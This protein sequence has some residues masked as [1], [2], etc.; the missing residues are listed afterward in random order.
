MS[1]K[2]VNRIYQGRVVKV[3]IKN[4]KKE[5]DWEEYKD[6]E[7]LLLNH[8]E[9]FQSAVNYYLLCFVALAGN[10]N[11][12][13]DNK[14]CPVYRLRE[15]MKEKWEPFFYKGL[16]R[17]G[18]QKSVGKHLFLDN[19]SPKFEECLKKVIERKENHNI[20]KESLHKALT[21]LLKSCS[22]SNSIQ[23]KGREFAPAFFWKSYSGQG[24]YKE[25]DQSKEKEEYF[26]QLKKDLWN[27]N[28]SAT[29][30]ARKTD[31][32]AVLNLSNKE[33]YTG[34]D[35]K[36]KLKEALEDLKKNLG[37][38]IDF[39]KEIEKLENIIDEKIKK[40]LKIP[41]YRGGG[42]RIGPRSKAFILF[43][44]V[45]ANP[46]TRENLKKIMP[47]S[48]ESTKKKTSKKLSLAVGGKDPIEY[49]R[50][51]REYIF[52]A[53]TALPQ[54]GSSDL[55][56]PNWKEFDIAAFK[57][58][59]TA[60]HQVD[61]KTKERE[62]KKIEHQKKLDW[63]ENHYWIDGKQN[64]K[65]EWQANNQDNEI[66]ED[67]PSFIGNFEWNPGKK[68]YE[69]K[70]EKP[71]DPRIKLLRKL[72]EQDLAQE[73]FGEDEGVGKIPYGLKKRTLRGF[74]EIRQKW[75]SKSK[76]K[77][78]SEELKNKLESELNSYQ[79]KNKYKIGSAPLFKEFLEKENWIIWQKPIE[80]NQYDKQD[81]SENPLEALCDWYELK[82]KIEKLNNPIQFTPADPEH[83]R[84]LFRFGDVASGFNKKSGNFGHD[85]NSLSFRVPVVFRT[86][87][88][89][90][91]KKIKIYYSA[92]RLFRDSLRKESG[93]KLETMP[94]LQPMM[95]AF[96]FP[97]DLKQNFAK[98]NVQLMPDKTQANK[99][100]FLLNFPVEIEFEKLQNQI[101]KDIKVD[102][103]KNCGAGGKKYLKWPKTS[104]WEG[105]KKMDKVDW[106]KEIDQFSCLSVDLGQRSAGAFALITA[107]SKRKGRS[108]YIGS[109]KDKKWYAS[110]E[111]MGIFRLPGEDMKFYQ[112]GQFKT[113]P[114]GYKGRKADQK[115]LDEAIKM[116]SCLTG[117]RI[118]YRITR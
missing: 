60:I 58:A 9:V 32:K 66:E 44:Y 71:G 92:P 115:E 104:Q 3:E 103:Q 2:T 55:G 8:H 75:Q 76:G 15:Q 39:K 93:E 99:W 108:R 80:Q 11:R 101:R 56:E 98:C 63:M 85:E 57:E 10:K 37:N 45:E 38:E 49:C 91:E 90:E 95:S 27:D 35:L 79:K 82:E 100:R 89:L 118:G 69:D 87:D 68:L 28:V 62:K 30:L 114:Y 48:K 109:V 113:E 31:P 65:T 54:W 14:T 41:S 21:A 53:F 20:D 25:S 84:R 105:D 88:V 107:S 74:N 4:S 67:E 12:P 7:T 112:K 50:G 110:I 96:G 59:L 29:D 1:L 5:N 106:F 64:K 77:E 78:F 18:M 61:E 94:W 34:N 47:K 19:P 51:E 46:A 117:K 102:W 70:G 26:E 6:W 72:L 116:I 13:S 73:Y 40:G 42:G 36:I 52:P 24:A 16:K 17:S 33:D 22:G 86:N 81:F 97:E 111:D 23:Q 83:S 43:K